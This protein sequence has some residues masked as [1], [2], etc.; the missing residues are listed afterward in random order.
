MKTQRVKRSLLVGLLALAAATLTAGR[1]SAAMLTV[2]PS[3][4]AFTQIAPALAAA[5]NG[6]T[7][8]IGAG[9]YN[10]GL[11]VDKSLKL[12]GA[13][14]GRT[15]ISGGGPVVTIGS[16]ATTSEPTVTID[17]VTITGGI[18]RSSWQ[19][20]VGVGVIARG[21]GVEIPLNAD[22]SGGATVTI[23]NS[24]ITA[25]RVA[26]T[27]TAPFGPPCPGGSPCP[28]AAA[29][30]GGIDNWGSLTLANTTVSNNLI[31]SAAGLG[32]LASD[33]DG[34]GISNWRGPLAIANSEIS[35]NQAAVSAPNG[36]SSDAGGI[37]LTGGKVTVSNTSVSDNSA[38]VSAALPSSVPDIGVA[39]GG[40]HLTDD[41]QAVTISNSSIS[42]NVATATNTLGDVSASSAGLH[43]D[44]G[45]SNLVTLSND[46]IVDNSARAAALSTGDVDA[47]AGAGE[48][49]GTLSNVRL[50]GNSVDASSAAGNATAEGGASV[51]DGGTITN[52]LVADNHVHVSSPHGSASMSGGGIFVAVDL[53]LRNTPVTGNTASVSGA[54]GNAFG[55][56]IYDVAF[57]FGQ[58]GPP[59]GPLVLQNSALTGNAL[60]GSAG[61]TLQ[62]GGLYLLGE[63]L[64]TSN[65]TIA[66]NAP[67][68]CF[69]C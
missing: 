34:A 46:V 52:G 68:D 8:S 38:T 48:V 36:R 21:G 6:D 65:S 16:H 66:Q 57:P 67:D 49:T 27:A 60:T 18:T 45:D 14:S 50:T 26:P 3:G 40:M 55:G 59:G 28:F 51:F 15:T 35:G 64:T 23:S 13:G 61:L 1:A 69:G 10:G 25:N 7:I 62:G 22:F 17:G 63:P 20:G 43:I 56:G 54:T 19:T 53:T 41:V 44:I 42:G 58:D 12:V 30:G 11:T 24:V 4:C 39:A 2:C 32:A 9:T 5:N 37:I 33:A 29:S 47:S 31:G